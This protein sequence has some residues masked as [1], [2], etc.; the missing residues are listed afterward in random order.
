MTCLRCIQF[1]DNEL[2]LFLSPPPS[3]SLT[4]T[5]SL[6]MPIFLSFLGIQATF[7]RRDEFWNMDSTAYYLEEVNRLAD[8]DFVPTEVRNSTNH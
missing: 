7:K 4:V 1:S 6:Y 3:L 2:A 8:E 5:L